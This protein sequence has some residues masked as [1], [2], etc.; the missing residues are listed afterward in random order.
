MTNRRVVITGMG[1]LTPLGIGPDA[2]WGGLME[3]RSAVRPVER[4]DI[5]DMRTT[6]YAQLPD[7]DFD[8]YLDAK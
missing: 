4:I 7:I 8:D 5:D 1:L 3:R 2:L 6:H